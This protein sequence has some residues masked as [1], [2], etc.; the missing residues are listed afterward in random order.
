M[1]VI[2][3]K[4][5]KEHKEGSGFARVNRSYFEIFVFSLKGSNPAG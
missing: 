2:A 4:E 5:H 1:K 3:A